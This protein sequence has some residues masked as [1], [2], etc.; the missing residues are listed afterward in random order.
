MTTNRARSNERFLTGY[1]VLALFTVL[2]GDAW[3]YSISWYGFGAV[4]VGLTVTSIVLLVRAKSRW[5]VSALPYPLLAFLALA[6]ASI[7]WSYYPGASAIGI[8][9]QFV[10]TLVALPIALLLD[11]P[12]LLAVIGRALRIILALSL[13]FELVVGVVVRRPVLPLWVDYG[14]ADVPDAF[15]WTRAEL[16][17]GGRIQGIVGN[18]N[19]LGMLA[20]LALIVFGIQLASRRVERAPGI[21]WL[22]LAALTIALTRSATVTVAI[23]GVAAVLAALLLVR[24]TTTPRVR[25]VV[26]ATFAAASVIGTAFVAIFGRGLLGLLGKS[27]DLTGRL[28][29]WDAVIALAQQRPAFGWGW[30]SYW[31]PWVEPFSDLAIRK[32]VRY[33]Q[34]H[35]AWLDVWLQLGIVGVVIL[36]LLVVSSFSRSW[37]LAVDRPQHAPGSTDSY[38]ALSL[39]PLLILSALIVQSAAESRLL[40]EYGWV[41]LVVVAVMT[42][43]RDLRATPLATA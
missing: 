9:L 32:G 3:R 34:A 7:A 6:L 16:F 35:N 19:T 29:I 21:A 2:A 33:L 31:A 42:K 8:T 24:L 37:S 15:Y 20:L 23:A 10:T 43:R 18:A 39:L 1:A 41:L 22:A 4:A 5:H 30:V 40:I 11:W 13:L 38:T 25:A 17:T 12:Q 36:A 26:V 27:E 28:D 14:G